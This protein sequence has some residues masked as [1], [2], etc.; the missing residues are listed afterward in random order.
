MILRGISRPI[1]DLMII[2]QNHINF[3]D[4]LIINDKREVTTMNTDHNTLVSR[5]N[6]GYARIKWEK[7]KPKN[8]NFSTLD[9]V[10]YTLKLEQALSNIDKTMRNVDELNKAIIP[11]VEDTLQ[12][13]AELNNK[14]WSKPKK[15]P[16]NEDLEDQIW[17]L[18]YQGYCIHDI[19][20]SVEES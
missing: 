19:G 4:A 1:L 5:L 15:A 3:I 17:D 14:K 13:T 18:E 6:T 16:A 8:Q 9:K 2:D 10:N 7:A 12:A 11:A 20:Y